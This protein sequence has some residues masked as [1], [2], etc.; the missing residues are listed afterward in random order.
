MALFAADFA[1]RM[2]AEV[3]AFLPLWLL[4]DDYNFKGEPQTIRAIFLILQMENPRP[5]EVK[6]LGHGHTA[7]EIPEIHGVSV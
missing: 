7:S 2:V 4:P 6:L 5:R 1:Q 3:S